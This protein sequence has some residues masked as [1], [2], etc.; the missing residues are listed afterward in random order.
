MSQDQ[1]VLPD[2]DRPWYYEKWFLIL[3]FILGWPII[4]SL[5][6]VLWPVWAILILRSPWHN[7]VL[8]NG[9]AWA[10][11]FTGIVLEFRNFQGPN[12]AAFSMALLAPGV[13]VTVATQ[14]MWSRFRLEHG[15]VVETPDPPAEPPDSPDPLPD[16]L[17]PLDETAARESR[18]RRRSQRRRSS[19]S[20]RSSR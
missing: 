19:R 4:N 2:L 6:F 16:S 20:S 11:L 3:V 15:L 8:I 14:V 10:M 7:H 13:V 5:P 12:G 1:S 17:D 9:L 18:A